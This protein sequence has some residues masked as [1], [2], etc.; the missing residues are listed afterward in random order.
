MNI[1]WT[2]LDLMVGY[3]VDGNLLHSQ[4]GL[5]SFFFL[6]KNKSNSSGYVKSRS[7]SWRSVSV[8]FFST[9]SSRSWIGKFLLP[10]LFCLHK[11]IIQGLVCSACRFQLMLKR[12]RNQKYYQFSLSEML[13]LLV[14]PLLDWYSLVYAAKCIYLSWISNVKAIWWSARNT[15]P[16][17]DGCMCCEPHNH[18]LWSLK[19]WRLVWIPWFADNWDEAPCR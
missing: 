6:K 5:C 14:F 9:R 11:W 16:L 7:P 18:W 19:F 15:T 2:E 4:T 12:M 8:R 3:H 10:V 17:S 1:N 13:K